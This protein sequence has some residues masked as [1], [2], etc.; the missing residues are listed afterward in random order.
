MFYFCHLLTSLFGKSH[1]ESQKKTSSVFEIYKD[2][3]GEYRF[4]LKAPNGE[5][6]LV[7]EGY[8]TKANAK[9]GVKSVKKNAP[10]NSRYQ[11]KKASDDQYMFNLKAANREI[12]GT[13]ETYT[14]SA[15]RDYG[16]QRVKHYAP[17]AKVVDLA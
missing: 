5:I 1:S 10:T 3:A 17:G 8:T 4:R 16:I 7:S 9:K 14:T 15:S 13:S 12:I 2:A 6:I 11:R